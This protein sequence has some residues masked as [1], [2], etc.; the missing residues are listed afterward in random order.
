MKRFVLPALALG[1]LLSG[2]SGIA[3]ATTSIAAA[4][5]I[6]AAASTAGSA[7]TAPTAPGRPG[8]EDTTPPGPVTALTMS[9]NGLRTISLKWTD[10]ANTD[11]AHVMIRR[12]VGDQPPLSAADGTVVAVLGKRTTD[13]TDRHLEPGTTYSYAVYAFDR[14]QNQST[15]ST[16]TASTLSTDNHTGIKGALTDQ[17]GHPI[18]GVWAEVR[19]AGSGNWAGQA[20]T[21]ADGSYRVPNLQPGSYTV[22]FEV[23]S[24]SSGPSTTGYL[25]GCYRQQP[26]GYGDSG[27]PVTVVAGKTTS[28]INDYLVVAGAIAGRITDSGGN[29]I[30][31]VD[32]YVTYPS[33]DY[34]FFSTNT[35]P[36]GSYT[37]TGMPADSYQICFDASYAT[38]PSSTGYLNECYDNQPQIFGGSATPI[39]VTLGHTS[40]GIDAV[41]DIGA[42]V[43]GTVTDPAGNP[44]DGAFVSL[45]PDSGNATNTDAQGHYTVTGAAPGVYTVCFEGNSAMSVGAPYGYTSDCFDGRPSF[46]LAAGQTVT[47]NS[48]LQAAG[49]L[50]GSVSGADG[51]VAG[52]WVNVFDASGAQVNGTSS[53]ENGNWQLPGFAPGTYTVCYD[54]SYTSGGY[55]RSCYH[56]QP[57]D[58]STGTPVT[59]TAGQLTTVE[60]TLQLGPAIAGTVTDSAGAPLSGVQISA[61][62]MSTG[63]SSYYATTDQDGNYT[64]GGVNPDTYSVCFDASDAHGPAAGG[65]TAECYDNQPSIETAD[66]VVVGDSGTVTVNAQLAAGGA[67]VGTVTDQNGG[68]VDGVSVVATSQS[69]GQNVYGNTAEDGSY[70]LPGLP[71]GAYTVCFHPNPSTIGPPTGYVE[72]CWQGQTIPYGGTPVSVTEGSVTSGID[73]RLSIGGEIIGTVTDGSDAPVADVWVNVQGTD[74]TWYDAWG[75]TDS[76]GHYSLLGLPAVPLAVCFEPSGNYLSQCYRNAPDASSATLVTPTSGGVSTGIDAVLQPAS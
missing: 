16:I 20:T 48:T 17:A 13:F 53:D 19:F 37:I 71:T 68:G 56:G 61:V 35:R 46:E 60:D 70:T 6:A 7:A 12:A 2:V 72:Q 41:L 62:P 36:D 23:T 50:G 45:I 18:A 32:V 64:L 73:A 3:T 69:S 14:A 40:A 76:S 74:G 47:Q 21:A 25:S 33:P 15:A 8:A 66:P 67:I 10:P 65:Y 59:V 63:T 34:S 24:Q 42:A 52:V 44:V 39:P 26:Y 51:P 1:M 38:G 49:G 29:G 30:G 9:G 27:T 28:D 54:P 22:C 5:P 57:D 43:T 11:L 75:Y 4:R 31:N 58:P 55:R